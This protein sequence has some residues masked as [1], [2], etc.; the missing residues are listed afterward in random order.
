MKKE[1]KKYEHPSFGMLGLSRI[2]GK[3]GYLFGSEI[4]SDNF[5]ELTLSEGEMNRELSND[6]FFA[7]K[8][9][10]KVKMSPNQFS[11]LIT[12]LNIGSGVPV[13]I[14]EVMGEK[15]EQCNDMESK[16]TYT[17]N[18]FKQRMA[19]FMSE[20]NSKYKEAEQIINKK[21]L[22]KDDQEKL[23]W[24]YQRMSQEIKQNIPFFVKCFQEVMDK[25]V[26]D[27]KSEIDSALLHSVVSAGIE[28]LGININKPDKSIGDK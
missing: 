8:T 13:T 26:L 14:E 28:A 18:Q 6:W 22:S 11:E 2:H 1:E 16:K 27:A 25:V 7:R 24:F 23:K 5:I 12:A 15:I 17:H 21:N 4:Q 9:L 20:I 3:S 19:E 10:F